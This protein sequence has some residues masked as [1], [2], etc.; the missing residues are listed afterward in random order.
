[1]IPLPISARTT[2]AIA[3]NIK[4]LVYPPAFLFIIQIIG[5]IST[6]VNISGGDTSKINASSKV[7]TTHMHA[8]H[9]FAGVLLQLVAPHIIVPSVTAIDNKPNKSIV[10]LFN[11]HNNSADTCGK[12][13]WE[14]QFRIY[15][16]PDI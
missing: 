8:T 1:M 12:Y 13:R 10:H 6:T 7:I 3:E 11:Y 15:P 5:I 14:K 4:S 16:A 2:N 9:S